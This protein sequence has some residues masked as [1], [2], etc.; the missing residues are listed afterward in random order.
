[1]CIRDRS[2][3]DR[4]HGRDRALRVLPALARE[5]SGLSRACGIQEISLRPTPGNAP[6][7]SPIRHP[8]PVGLGLGEGDGV[9]I[10]RAS[11]RDRIRGSRSK[12]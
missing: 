3:L 12:H 5:L 2:N 6:I 1:M 9:W 10:L 11:A 7:L 4:E 8:T